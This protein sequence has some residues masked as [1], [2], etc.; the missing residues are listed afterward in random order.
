MQGDWPATLEPA[1]RKQQGRATHPN[2]V[3]SYDFVMD[4]TEIGRRL[5]ML[6][7][8][9]EHTREAHAILVKGSI[10]AEVGRLDLRAWLVS[11]ARL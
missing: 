1:L 11:S 6:P 9:D 7:V 8:V 5:K 3:W 2:H 4:Q 10:T